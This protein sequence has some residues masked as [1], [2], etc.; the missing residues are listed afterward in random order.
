MSPLFGPDA[1]RVQSK[2]TR[3]PGT[4][5]GIETQV[6]SEESSTRYCE[7]AVE[8]GGTVYGIRQDLAP[9]D[10]IRLGMPVTLAIDGT[11]A[12]IEWADSGTNRWKM[13]KTPPVPG[14]VDDLDG[15]GNRGAM[16]RVRRGTPVAVTLLDFS[17]RKVAFGLGESVDAAVRAVPDGG[18]DPI[19][20]TIPAMQQ[21]PGYA[22]HLVVKGAT[23]PGWIRSGLTGTSIVIDWAAA[24]NA[25]PGVGRPPAPLP[26][27]RGGLLGQLAGGTAGTEEADDVAEAAPELPAFAQKLLG[28]AG[29]P[30][31]GDGTGGAEGAADVVSWETFLD[32]QHQIDWGP[33]K[34]KEIEDYAVSRGVPPGEWPAAQRRWQLRMSSDMA[35]VAEYGQRMSRP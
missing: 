27:Q 31:E 26:G 4:I 24:A 32:V 11:N 23:L 3:T 5:I 25:D 13:L 6:T 29:V 18:G 8:A 34:K 15:S 22:S 30:Q 35:L 10:G 9:D 1:G 7:Y 20:T 16:K 33:L 2:G 19:E 28:R 14:I 12:V 21:A 17:V